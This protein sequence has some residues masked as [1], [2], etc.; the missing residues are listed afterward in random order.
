MLLE[1]SAICNKVLLVPHYLALCLNIVTTSYS[2]YNITT[3]YPNP[4]TQ[5][6][7]VMEG[8]FPPFRV[9]GMSKAG[10]MME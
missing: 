8:I 7:K 6:L 2:G 9:K 10:R 5:I 4:I 1:R 3:P